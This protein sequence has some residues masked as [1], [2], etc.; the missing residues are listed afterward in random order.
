M[1]DFEKVTVQY[2][3]PQKVWLTVNDFLFTEKNQHSVVTEA[4][5]TWNVF[6]IPRSDVPR[7]VLFGGQD[8]CPGTLK[9]VQVL[10]ENSI[11]KVVSDR[12]RFCIAFSADQSKI[13]YVTEAD[14]IKNDS[15]LLRA[16]NKALALGNRQRVPTH[17][18]EMFSIGARPRVLLATNVRDEDNIVEWVTYHQDLGFDSI[19]ILDHKSTI[20]V[21]SVLKK[22]GLSK[23]V[24]VMPQNVA[25]RHLMK[26]DFIQMALMYARQ[27]HF[28][29]MLYIDGDEYL[30]LKSDI[31]TVHDF[32]ARFP[33]QAN[34]IAAH[35]LIFGSNGLSHADCSALIPT[36]LKSDAKFDQHVKSFVRPNRSIGETTCGHYYT[37]PNPERSV[38]DVT[39]K[40]L[41]KKSP[42]FPVTIPLA[43]APAFIAHYQMQSFDRFMKHRVKMPRDDTNQFR[44]AVK[45]SDFHALHNGYDNLLMLHRQ[46]QH[47][48]NK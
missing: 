13:I 23:N 36:F 18:N 2:G 40:L 11:V 47:A 32:L 37:V 9:V 42:T 26:N 45:E 16:M 21:Q 39:G 44:D 15:D 48:N 30:Y 14:L 19:L 22:H 27:H 5:E 34:V 41:G 38:Y 8:P 1:C 20:P 7:S 17:G 25:N 31:K 29:W 33:P 12:E 10:Q 4:N 35:W 28:A 3:H 24:V 43:N 6:Q 46:Q